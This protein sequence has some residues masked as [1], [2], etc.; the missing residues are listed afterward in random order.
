M[1]KTLSLLGAALL[2]MAAACTNPQEPKA[3][4]MV[5]ESAFMT[6]VKPLSEER[7]Q[8]YPDNMEY[9]TASADED[10][11]T[12]M[13]YTSSY[14]HKT[15][16]PNWVAYELTREEASGTKSIDWSFGMDFSVKGR[17]ASREDYSHSGW[18]RGHMA[19]RA[20]MRWSEQAIKESYYFT[21]AC[22]QNKEMNAGVW[23]RLEGKA[24]HA[25]KRFGSVYV[26]CGPIFT[27]G[28]NG[29]IGRN[30][31]KVPDAFFK[32]LLAKTPKGYES[33]AFVIENIEE[34]QSLKRCAMSVDDLEKQ[35]GRDLFF[36]M[37][38][39]LEA[40][41]ESQYDVKVWAL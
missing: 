38:D 7:Q 4:A 41:V 20:D 6:S 26:V 27:T 12:Y 31:V 13:C 39:K 10:I 22:P 32:A 14:N 18:D 23:A 17:Q 29:T 35:L 9:P 3:G 19:P 8:H 16:C 34:D 30:K 5:E 1:N 33:I 15:L 25:A 11:I 21:N 37:E 36:N 24:R 2:M 28:A 40:V